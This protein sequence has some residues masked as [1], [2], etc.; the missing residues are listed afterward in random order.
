MSTWSRRAV[1]AASW[2]GARIGHV[3]AEGLTL[4][5]FCLIYA[6]SIWTAVGTLGSF[7]FQQARERSYEQISSEFRRL[8]QNIFQDE[9]VQQISERRSRIEDE[10][11]RLASA[12]EV[13]RII[14]VRDRLPPGTQAQVDEY[15][16]YWDHSQLRAAIFIC[17]ELAM[18]TELPAA[19]AADC[20][21]ALGFQQQLS[22]YD[23]L[24]W[25]LF[26]QQGRLREQWRAAN[27][28][29]ANLINFVQNLGLHWLA[30]M[31]LEALVLFLTMAMGL[32]GSVLRLTWMTS[33]R[34]QPR[35]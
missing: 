17:A 25:E 31:P 30:T 24:D 11:F 28:G 29:A 35:C 14:E 8:E 7:Q 32:L 6:L 5:W 21:T 4:S 18:E 9:S 2:L 26:E 1:G 23:R 34:A 33:G 27:R 20:D 19:L 10:L 12:P 3:L 22:E 16:F 15:L 13:A